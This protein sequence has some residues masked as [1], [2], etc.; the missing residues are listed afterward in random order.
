MY[1]LVMIFKHLRPSWKLCF[2]VVF[3]S[4][5]PKLFYFK[6][7]YHLCKFDK[8]TKAS[9]DQIFFSTLSVITVFNKVQNE[10]KRLDQPLNHVAFELQRLFWNT[11]ISVIY[12]I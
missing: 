9:H 1:E 7:V 8:H 12:K 10:T 4:K 3:L 5:K 11:A 6:F 2:E